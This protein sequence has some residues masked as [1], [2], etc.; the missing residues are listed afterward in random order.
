MRIYNPVP[1]HYGGTR[2]IP[3]DNIL[4]D[5]F[6][7]DSK[8]SYFIQAVDVIAHALYRKEYVKG[9]L[10]KYGVNK[11]LD[12]SKPILLKEASNNDP[13]GIVRK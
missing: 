13:L 8:H 2:N 7:R 3:T 4:E 11:L 5:P 9:S 1:S 6:L 12:T 10:R